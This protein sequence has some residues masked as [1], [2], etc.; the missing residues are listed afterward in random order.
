MKKIYLLVLLLA[1]VVGAVMYFTRSTTQVGSKYY[2]DYL[3]TDTLVTVSL[4]DLKGLADSFPSSSLGSFLAKQTMHGI[5]TELG[6]TPE[7]LNGYDEMYDGV[8]DVM[9]NPAFR[10]VFGDDAVIALLSPD[11]ER[12]QAVPEQEL[13]RSLLVLGTSSV[14]GPLDS[15]ARLVMSK[16]VSKETVDGVEL[17]RIQLDENQVIYG[18]AEGGILVLAW[19]P[20]NIVSAVRQKQAGGGLQEQA[21]FMAAGKFWSGTASGREYAQTYINFATVRDILVASNKEDAIET[22][23]YLQGFKGAGSVIVEREGALHIASRLEYD[24][25]SLNELVKSQ[26]KSLAQQNLSLGLLTGKTL[27]Y[28]W[29][30]TLGKEF[31]REIFSA[32]GEEQ[33]KQADVRVREELGLSIE[34]VIGAVGPQFG[35]ALNDVVNT[36]LFPLPKVILFLQIRDNTVA[37]QVLDKLRKEIAEGGFAAEQSTQVNGHTIYFWPVL[38]AEAAQPALVLT[39]NM[40]Y[41]ANGKSSLEELVAEG[42]SVATLPEA[43]AKS[44]GRE[45]VHN[46]ETSNY[47]TFVMRPARMATEVKDAADWVAGMLDAS[48]GVPTENL[49]QEILKLMHSVDVVTATSDIQ[50]DYAAST[51]VFTYASDKD[52]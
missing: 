6:A 39:D 26:Y 43:T 5:L 40:L 22:A 8:A 4:V 34:E 49:K 44:L 15:F 31:I 52:K 16:S 29:T 51:L 3:P 45:I 10:Q 33:Y 13:Q 7:G 27:A 41:L 47:S 30:S 18:Y 46:I 20:G 14:S 35:L 9:T 38:P 1:G 2:A 50:T 42:R 23:D 19:E 48:K 12:L 24:F 28:Y 17:T 25:D 11:P 32:T 36:G 37:R 21:F